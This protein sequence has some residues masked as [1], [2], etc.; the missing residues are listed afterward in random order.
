MSMETANQ[1]LRQWRII[2]QSRGGRTTTQSRQQT[3]FHQQPSPRTQLPPSEP[4][5]EP[6]TSDMER[7]KITEPPLPQKDAMYVR[8]QTHTPP[9]ETLSAQAVYAGQQPQIPPGGRSPL[10]PAFPTE[11]V[12]QRPAPAAYEQQEAYEYQV[13]SALSCTI[14]SHLYWAFFVGTSPAAG[15]TSPAGGCLRPS[16]GTTVVPRACTAD[17][18]ASSSTAK[19]GCA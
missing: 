7:M 10:R 6:L 14:S 15:C 17:A 16:A 11:P 4:Q 9:P 5:I 3:Q 19:T 18:A 2:N 13:C 8:P 12:S 1:L